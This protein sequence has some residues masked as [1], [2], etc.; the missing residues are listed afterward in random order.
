[1][2]QIGQFCNFTL[3]VI[4]EGYQPNRSRNMG[5]PNACRLR[6]HPSTTANADFVSEK[7]AEGVRWGII[8]PFPAE[9]LYCILHL[10]VAINAAGKQRLI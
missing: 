8:P 6:N 2:R 4:N 1:M 3:S 7:V 9:S 5:T 10:E